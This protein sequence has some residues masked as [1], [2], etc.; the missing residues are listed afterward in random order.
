MPEASVHKNCQL[1]LAKDKIWIAEY[2]RMA[3]PAGDAAAAEKL[4]QG[5][6]RLLVPTATDARHHLRSFGFGEYVRHYVA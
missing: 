5:H 3:M 1:E 4:H 2:C 6:F